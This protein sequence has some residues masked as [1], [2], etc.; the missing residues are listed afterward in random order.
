MIPEEK[1]IQVQPQFAPFLSEEQ[2]QQMHETALRVLEEVGLKVSSQVL[3]RL[4]G[5][6]GV[7]IEGDRVHLSPDLVDGYVQE[8]RRRRSQQTTKRDDPITISVGS[9][10]SHIVDLDTDAVRP[11]TTK[12]LVQCTRL[13]DAMHTAGYPVIGQ[14]PGFPADVPLALRPLMQY[15]IGAE[16]GRFGGN[17]DVPSVEIAQYIRRMDEVMGRKRG[18]SMPLYMVSPLRME[19]DSLERILHFLEERPNISV[20]SMPSI[21]VSAPIF[22][23]GAFVLSIAEVLGGYAVL[24]L[25]AGDDLHVSYSFNAHPFDMKYTT[26]IFGSPEHNLCELTQFAVNR[27]YG[28]ERHSGRALRSMAKRP[29]VQATAE[30]SASAVIAALAGVRSFS[31]GGTLALDEV[32]SGEQLVIDCE[33]TAYAERFIRGYEF[34]EEALGFHIIRDTAAAGGFLAHGTTLEQYREVLRMPALFHHSRLKRWKDQGEPELREEAKAV[35]REMIAQCDFHLD[36]EKRRGLEEIYREA[37]KKL[38]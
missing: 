6:C 23:P 26:M 28:V 13:V 9:Y 34:S 27:F 3:E 20:S 24:K 19:A 37:E 2:L 15:R 18:F 5:Q 14:C 31:G 33:I 11:A 36:G 32:F 21:G 10:A 4:T 12:D 1:T 17:A 8:A 7:L 22:F 16:N 29:G 25:L 35:A 38:L 30:K